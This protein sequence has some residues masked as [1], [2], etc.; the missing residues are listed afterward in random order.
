M[1]TL[2]LNVTLFNNNLRFFLSQSMG[3]SSMHSPDLCLFW[4]FGRAYLCL[5]QSLVL[6]QLPMSSFTFSCDECFGNIVKWK[7]NERTSRS[8]L[9]SFFF[10]FYDDLGWNPLRWPSSNPT[11]DTM[12]VCEVPEA[13][14]SVNDKT[15]YSDEVYFNTKVHIYNK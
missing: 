13:G 15:T 12:V 9:S 2:L 14:L 1:F 10:T 8:F 4:D 7:V 11:S 6:N 5:R 3:L